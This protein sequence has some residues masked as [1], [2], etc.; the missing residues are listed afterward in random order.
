MLEVNQLIGFGAFSDAAPAP[1]T[2]VA[3]N[4]DGTNDWL[5]RGAG[6]T[7]AADSKLIT[8]SGW[9]KVGVDDTLMNVW[10]SATTAGGATV[11][12]R[13]QR[14]ADNSLRLIGRNATPSTILTIVSSTNVAQVADGWV[15]F[16]FSVDLADTGK[17]HIYIN[18]ASDLAT[19]DTYTNDTMD[20]TTGDWSVGAIPAGTGKLT[21]DLA[22]LWIAPGVYI[23]FS[24]EANRRL[25]IDAGGKPVD[26]GSDGSTPTG[27]APL[28]FF[29]N[30]TAT[31]HTNAGS[32]GGFTENGAITD[33]ADSPS[34]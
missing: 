13:V 8:V 3:V 18:D 20:F 4:F 17:R 5:T 31:W 30:P 2:A 22:D 33:A 26:L 15:H 9:L 11:M 1:Y 24:V 32:G 29:T 16:L 6:L 28:M 19:V 23:D 7:G 10:S 21:G 27:T 34:D 12:H 14:Q 25:F